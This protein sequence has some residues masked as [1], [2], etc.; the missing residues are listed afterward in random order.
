[1]RTQYLQIGRLFLSA[2]EYSLINS[3]VPRLRPFNL[4][5]VRFKV[6]ILSLT[7]QFFW[8]LTA[9]LLLGILSALS[10]PRISL[11]AEWSFQPSIGL[12]TGRDDNATLTTGAHESVT[13]VSIYPRM[14]WAKTTETS[15][16]NLDLL[17]SATEYS[18]NQ[19]PDT[20]AQTL[21]LNSYVQTTER[22]KWG[23]DSEFRREILFESTE[24]TAGT[25]N[26]RDTDVG[27][28]TQKVRRESLLARPSWNH[29]LTERSSLG[30][31][32]EINDVSFT[33]IAGTGLEDYKDHRVAATYAYRITQRDDLNF[34]LAHS[35]YRPDVSNTKSDSNQ[36]L[37]GISRA[38]TE[39]A[40][41]RFMVGVGETSEK[42]S[43]GT[44]DSSNYVLEAGLEQRSELTT[45]DG[46]ISR[47]V[48]PSGA[49]RSV[50]SNQF[51]INLSRKI[52]PMVNLNIRANV[53]R[54][55]VLEG[56]D[57]DVDRRYYELIP[58]LS[59]QWKPEWAFGLEYQYRKQKFDADP[60]TAKSNALFAGVKYSWPKQ[61]TSR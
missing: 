48:Q 2:P 7:R 29:A 31:N 26:L 3:S 44:D 39:T 52:S 4:Q 9:L 40:R 37:V 38:F 56:S 1:M 30:L 61:V 46:V 55:K 45:V 47:D 23:L 8:S 18:G 36:L 41:G 6:A 34:T 21:T 32:Y 49:G 58:G 27:L 16:V 24:S 33:N 20:D 53:F 50:L 54:N 51:R 19:V 42:T 43:A 5:P 13:A 14:K 35:A 59:W 11:A 15:A 10:L 60:E 17:L 12:A 22:T 25:G 28:V 57:P